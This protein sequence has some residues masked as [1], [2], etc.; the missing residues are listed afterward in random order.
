MAKRSLE[1]GRRHMQRG[2]ALVMS[3]VLLM[4]L[5]LL[6]VSGMN[7]ASLEF[8]MAGNEQYHANAF[9]ASE[10]GIA[11]GLVQGAFNPANATEVI[12][13]GNNGPSDT[14][15]AS[16]VTQLGGRP[17]G[18]LP[19]FTWGSFSTYHFEVDATGAST[20]GAASQTQQGVAVISPYDPTEQPD[21]TLPSNQ[22]N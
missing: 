15:T 18:A 8:I 4:V 13:A 22:L 6:A 1:C 20:R 16:V 3:L 5:T 9:Q 14:W 17:Q 11:Q 21:P 7:S 19:L 10:A 12:P 2:A